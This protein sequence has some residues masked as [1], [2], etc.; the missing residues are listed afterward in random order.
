MLED[1][2]ADLRR[3]LKDYEPCSG[4]KRM[5]LLLTLNSVHAV[6]LIR[7]QLWCARK[8]WPTIVFSK[9]LFWFFKIE[10]NKNVEIGPGL[11]L[12]HPM[13][14]LIG[15]NAVLGANC[16][17]YAD[18]RLVL[19]KGIKQGP[20]LADGV[21]MGDGSKALGPIHIGEYSVIGA[22]AVVTSDIPARVTAAGVPARVLS[23]N[24]VRS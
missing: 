22:S 20:I 2:K 15:P 13:G 9:L 14:I 12:P 1:L 16:D 10:I 4:L 11:R 19:T 8:G 7:M 23:R 5:I 18:V 21:F 6:M 3:N 17:V 24:I